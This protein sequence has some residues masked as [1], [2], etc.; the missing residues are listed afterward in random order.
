MQRIIYLC[1]ILIVTLNNSLFACSCS[2]E[3]SIEEEFAG[4]DIVFTG[5]VIKIEQSDDSYMGSASDVRFEVLKPY[6]G[7]TDRVITVRTSRYD[8]SCGYSFEEGK[9]YLVYA[10]FQHGRLA[11]SS[12]SRTGKLSERLQ[13]LELLNRINSSP[14]SK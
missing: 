6:K 9:Q 1:I 14:A 10:Y 4:V 11:A 12:C 3:R 13:D 7:T 2:K 5:K 8:I